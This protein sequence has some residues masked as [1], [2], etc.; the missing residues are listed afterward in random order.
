MS[1]ELPRVARIRQRFP[2]EHVADVAATVREKIRATDLS[3][4]LTPGA[5]IAITAGSRGI[6]QIPVVIGA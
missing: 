3:K 6:A 1:I 5:R 2:R 4:R